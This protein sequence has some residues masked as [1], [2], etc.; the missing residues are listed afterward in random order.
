MLLP[1]LSPPFLSMYANENMQMRVFGSCAHVY[2]PFYTNEDAESHARATCYFRTYFMQMNMQMKRFCLH[3][4]LVSPSDKIA[5]GSRLHRLPR[6]RLPLSP[7][8]PRI[9]GTRRSG[10]PDSLLITKFNVSLL[11]SKSLALHEKW[12]GPISSASQKD[13]PRVRMVLTRFSPS[14][15]SSGETGWMRTPGKPVL[16]GMVVNSPY[17]HCNIGKKREKLLRWVAEL[18]NIGYKHINGS[19]YMYIKVYET[20]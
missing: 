5:D 8:A 3:H 19:T 13:L 18:T 20:V 10:R 9:F 12:L 1:L 16:I 15:N 17:C 11:P 6:H 14:F 7:L 2:F 4:V